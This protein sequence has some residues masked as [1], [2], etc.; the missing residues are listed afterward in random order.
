M[1]IGLA[2]LLAVGL[3]VP[4]MAAEVVITRPHPRAEVHQ[5]NKATKHEYK[6]YRAEVHG[7][8]GKA[9]KQ[10]WK[11]D[12]SYNRAARDSTGRVTVITR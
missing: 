7:N 11:A 5:L 10:E 4:A 8:F 6:A 2:L 1:R 9:A 12:R 3:S